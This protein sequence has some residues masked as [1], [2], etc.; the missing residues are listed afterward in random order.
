ME[1]ILKK[2]TNSG[3]RKSSF[4]Y[5]LF[6]TR[7]RQQ[8]INPIISVSRGFTAI[9]IWKWSFHTFFIFSFVYAPFKRFMANKKKKTRFFESFIVCKRTERGK[10]AI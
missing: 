2:Q 7:Q 3:A 6:Q 10:Q 4:F 1:K 9:L 5:F 8:A